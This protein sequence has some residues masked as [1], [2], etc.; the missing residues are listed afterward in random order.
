MNCYSSFFIHNFDG[1]F[2]YFAYAEGL[3]LDFVDR[4]EEHTS[5]L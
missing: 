5:E 3:A 1:F 2:D 4:S